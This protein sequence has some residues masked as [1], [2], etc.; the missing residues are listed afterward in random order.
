MH[1]N[2]VGAMQKAKLLSRYRS[3]DCPVFYRLR[4]APAGYSRM[5]PPSTVLCLHRY[6]SR[7]DANLSPGTEGPFNRNSVYSGV[8]DV[9]ATTRPQLSGTLSA[10]SMSAVGLNEFRSQIGLGKR[11]AGSGYSGH[12]CLFYYSRWTDRCGRELGVRGENQ[13][14]CRGKT[15]AWKQRSASIGHRTWLHGNELVIRPT[16]R[17]AGD[18]FPAPCGS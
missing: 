3:C 2:P 12:R 9:Y 14:E 10:K 1:L 17:E 7:K 13:K 8:T 16:E 5:P 4:R 15:E 11:L 18:D 6:P